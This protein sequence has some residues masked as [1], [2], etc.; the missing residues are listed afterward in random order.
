MSLQ[1]QPVSTIEADDPLLL[2]SGEM[3]RQGFYA[4]Q[5][6]RQ[7]DGKTKWVR[8]DYGQESHLVFFCTGAAAPSAMERAIAISTCDHK[9]DHIHFVTFMSGEKATVDWRTLAKFFTKPL[10]I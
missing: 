5:K 6:G 10:M 9:P 3:C 2:S 1:E 4:K 8:Y 7:R